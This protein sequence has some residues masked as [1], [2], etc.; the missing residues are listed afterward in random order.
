M[1]PD[2]ANRTLQV[3]PDVFRSVG[4][5]T[6]LEHIAVESQL[7]KAL[8]DRPA[9][10]RI[11]ALGVAA[12]CDDD[13]IALGFLLIIQQIGR[14]ERYKVRVVVRVHGK[15]QRRGV[16]LNGCDILAP[17]IPDGLL[18]RLR[19]YQRFTRCDG[20][21]HHFLLYIRQILR[22]QVHQPIGQRAIGFPCV[23]RKGCGQIANKLII[24]DFCFNR[25]LV[26]V[27]C[28][29]LSRNLLQRDVVGNVFG[30]SGC[31]EKHQACQK[32]GRHFSKRTQHERTSFFSKVLWHLTYLYSNRPF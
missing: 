26:I 18:Q 30:H 31:T 12:A 2:I 10:T 14:Q 3:H 5:H 32:T 1:I 15:F 27:V 22:I 17:N 6:A 8:G 20:V 24:V 11:V 13:Q 19:L 7:A 28:P 25:F 4:R 29:C 23:L 9:F 16:F 21:V